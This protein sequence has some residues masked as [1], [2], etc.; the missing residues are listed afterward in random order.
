[1]KKT[2][3]LFTILLSISFSQTGIITPI[4]QTGMVTPKGESAMG[5]WGTM[6]K[7]V[8][9]N[10]CVERFGGILSYM[11]ENG[12]EMGISYQTKE[13]NSVDVENTIFTMQYHFKDNFKDKNF[14]IGLS[15]HTM[16]QSSYLGSDDEDFTNLDFVMYANNLF[17]VALRHSNPDDGDDDFQ[18][19]S[20]GKIWNLSSFYFSVNHGIMIEDGKFSDFF[21]NIDDGLT[22][23]GIGVTF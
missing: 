22:S 15:K 12:V 3:L 20:F 17:S 21:E 9:C 10:N 5:L 11:M 23:I 16:S 1:M 14:S 4:H 18:Y 19:I 13:V 6:S 2:I 8:D 7:V